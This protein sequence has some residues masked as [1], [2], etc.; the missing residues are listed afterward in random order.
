MKGSSDK[1]CSSSSVH[2]IGLPDT[3]SIMADDLIALDVDEAEVT[4]DLREFRQ[5][6]GR[7]YGVTLEVDHAL[8]DEIR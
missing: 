3:S 4:I 5:V 2:A 6:F 7:V 8:V 1:L